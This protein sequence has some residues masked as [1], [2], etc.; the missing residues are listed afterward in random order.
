MDTVILSMKIS[1]SILFP[2]PLS[3][4]LPFLL[5]TKHMFLAILLIQQLQV[6]YHLHNKTMQ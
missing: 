2:V 6:R 3:F 1:G 5:F 4:L